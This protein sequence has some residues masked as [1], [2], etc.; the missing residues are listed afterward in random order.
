MTAQEA[1]KKIEQLTK[2]LNEH[3]Y[4]YY[5]LDKPSI[6]DFQFDQMLNELIGL[7][8]DFPALLSP[9]SPS[10]RVGGQI[11]K[12]F[13]AVKHKYPMMSLGNTYSREELKDFDVR[14][15]KTLDHNYEY[16]CE[17]KFDG[18]SIGLT[19]KDGKLFQAVTRGDGVQGDEVTTNVKTIRSIPLD[20]GKGDYPEEFEVRGEIYMPLKSFEKINK[21]IEKQMMEDGYIE[22]EIFEKLLKNPRN[23]AS[24]T[25]KM[26][27]SKVVSKRNLDCFLYALLADDL[28]VDSHFAALKKLKQWGFKISEHVKC[29]KSMDQ[30]FEYI[31]FWEK[32]RTK[33]PFEIDGIVIKINSFEEQRLLGFTAKS[34]RWAISYKYKAESVSTKLLSVS[35]Q[36]GRTGAITPVA[37]LQPVFLAGT[38]VKRASLHNADQIEKLGLHSGDYIFV[39]KGGEIIPK[40]TAVDLKKREKNSRKIKYIDVCPECGTALIRKEEEANHYCPNEA[41]CPP[42]IK[43]KIEHFISRKAMNIDS[44]GEG[45]VE[46]L[47]DNDLIRNPADL[48]KLK[49]SQLLGLEK[50]FE[51]EEGEKPRKVSLQEKSVQKI[52]AGIEASREVP[53]ERVLYAIGIRYV[54]ETVAKKLALHFKNMDAIMNASEEELIMADEIGDKIAESLISFFKEKKH[55]K[56]IEQLRDAGLKMEISESPQPKKLSSKLE[57]CSFVVSGTF[58]NFSRDGI[59]EVIEQHGGKTQSGVSAK[60]NFLLA[61][62]EAGP[63]KLEK[64]KK[65]NVKIIDEGEF[66]KMIN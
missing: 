48:Y 10:Q 37:N 63:S 32:E 54:G 25:V 15:R 58:A 64:A 33:L 43:G 47:F 60:T 19:Y 66:Q 8:K 7:E 56:M 30:V 49:H 9:E 2:E 51:S 41:G 65:L 17:L 6:S 11:T 14:V 55:V 40:I 16:V 20:L 28:N 21:D 35:Y 18:L 23:A 22:E 34:P 42:Q 4:K 29:C 36:V 45:K 46:M 38:T 39:E 61:G 5:V 53:F 13:K 59:K 12:T 62:D 31:D 52:L 44:L 57:G 3:N 26:Q 27:D 50:V 24:G 1:K